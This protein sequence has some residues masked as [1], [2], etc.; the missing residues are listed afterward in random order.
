M[1]ANE[2]TGAVVGAL[3][4]QDKDEIMLIT[5]KAQMVRICVKDI[6]E[7]GRNA[8]GVKLM[9]LEEGDKLQALAPVI[10]DEESSAEETAEGEAGETG[11][12]PPAGPAPEN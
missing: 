4:V 12:T 7:T 1:K 10:S 9:D 8:Q 11:S 6:R 5:A 2:R 3:T